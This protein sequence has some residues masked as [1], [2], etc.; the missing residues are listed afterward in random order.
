M[1]HRIVWMACLTTPK[2]CSSS[3]IDTQIGWYLGFAGVEPYAIR[4][5]AQPLHR[6]LT[7][8]CHDDHTPVARL[9]RT[10]HNQE[11]AVQYARR[12]SCIRG[13]L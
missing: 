10:I 6:V 5:A 4:T 1:A 12:P 9:G 13:S 3:P 7:I 8:D 11:I 2:T